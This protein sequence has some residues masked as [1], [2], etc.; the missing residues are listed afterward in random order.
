MNRDSKDKALKTKV[1]GQYTIYNGEN[2]GFDL[3]DVSRLMRRRF[4]ECLEGSPLTQSQAR[5]LVY[6]SRCQGVRQVELAQML[7][8]QPIT[9]A[10]VV[11]QLQAIDLVERRA[12]PKDRRAYQLFLTEEAEPHLK[13]IEKATASLRKEVLESISEEEAA[14]TMAALDKLRTALSKRK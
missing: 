2:I 8:V 3:T 7:E 12:D 1:S 6:L 11:D 10:R 14:I 9:L 13:V 4:E 5:A